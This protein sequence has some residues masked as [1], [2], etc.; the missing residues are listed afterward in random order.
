MKKNYNL[1]LNKG[2]IDIFVLF[3]YLHG[4]TTEEVYP[5]HGSKIRLPFSPD[6]FNEQQNLRVN[7]KKTAQQN[8]EYDCKKCVRE[9]QQKENAIRVT[10]ESKVLHEPFQY[11]KQNRHSNTSKSVKSARSALPKHCTLNTPVPR[12]SAPRP[13]IRITPNENVSPSKPKMS[14][15]G[16]LDFI[17]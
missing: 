7:S 12:K 10:K 14:E 3:Q 8:I 16:R 11:A 1:L 9:L 6:K 17:L 2:S 13:S 5:P 15:K 4:A